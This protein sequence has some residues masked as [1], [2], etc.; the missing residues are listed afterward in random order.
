VNHAGHSDLCILAQKIATLT[1]KGNT[2]LLKLQ[3]CGNLEGKL[4]SQKLKLIFRP[5]CH[6]SRVRSHTKPGQQRDPCTAMC[7]IPLPPPSHRRKDA[8]LCWR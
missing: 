8:S 5:G 4:S 1:V 6:S 2:W 7:C 3:Q